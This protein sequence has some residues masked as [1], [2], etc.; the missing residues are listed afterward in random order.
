MLVYWGYYPFYG[1][2]GS[3]VI[4]VFFNKN[5][6]TETGSLQ[7]K[8]FSLRYERV[9]SVSK[10]SILHS[11]IWYSATNYKTLMVCNLDYW[12]TI[13]SLALESSP[14]TRRRPSMSLIMCFALRVFGGQFRLIG[15]IK[16]VWSKQ[17]KAYLT[18]VVFN[19]IKQNTH[20]FF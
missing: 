9:Y 10:F 11:E 15:I 14:A 20:G 7:W 8:T 5:D 4:F 13:D 16:C 2:G 12:K 19:L 18:L 6:I 1:R 3:S 17:K